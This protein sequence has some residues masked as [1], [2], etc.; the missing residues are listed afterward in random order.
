MTGLS[1]DCKV[2]NNLSGPFQ[3]C[4]SRLR[5]AFM[6]PLPPQ[7]LLPLL[8]ISGVSDLDAVKR[9]VGLLNEYIKK[10]NCVN[11]L[12]PPFSV[13]QSLSVSSPF[14][15]FRFFKSYLD[16][17]KSNVGLWNEWIKTSYC[18][19]F[20]VS[21]YPPL[22]VHP[23]SVSF[24]VWTNHKPVFGHM[25]GLCHDCKLATKLSNPFQIGF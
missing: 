21:I 2:A 4:I 19:F 5:L 18:V 1:H 6:C 14:C 25:T 24:S 16:S 7:R 20:P 17:V 9:N 12:P 3:I 13:C 22:I 15:Y 11:S 10:S 23:P 8:A